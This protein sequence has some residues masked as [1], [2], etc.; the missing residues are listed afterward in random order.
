[1]TQTKRL[2]QQAVPFASGFAVGL[3]EVATDQ[4]RQASRVPGST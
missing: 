2:K 1:M 3:A 4:T